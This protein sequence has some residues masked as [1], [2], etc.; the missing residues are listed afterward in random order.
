M[1]VTNFILRPSENGDAI[2]AVAEFKAD[3][4][5]TGIAGIRRKLVKPVNMQAAIW[6]RRSRTLTYRS[7]I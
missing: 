1:K 3:M 7:H 2:G 4:N 6:L 5:R